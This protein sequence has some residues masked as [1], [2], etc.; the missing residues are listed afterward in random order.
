MLRHCRCR[1]NGFFFQILLIRFCSTYDYVSRSLSAAD[2]AM[3]SPSSLRHVSSQMARLIVPMCIPF[4]ITS[5]DAEWLGGHALHAEPKPMIDRGRNVNA[6]YSQMTQ[7]NGQYRISVRN[8]SHAHV[9]A[10]EASSSR[11]PADQSCPVCADDESTHRELFLTNDTYI[12]DERQSSS[13]STGRTVFG[14]RLLIVVSD[15]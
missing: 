6:V 13:L 5:H 10:V 8:K 2:S 14:R 1:I 9:P 12:M 7:S 4:T 15:R 3:A 11:L